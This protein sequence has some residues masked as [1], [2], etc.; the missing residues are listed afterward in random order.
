MALLLGCPFQ[1]G[2]LHAAHQEQGAPAAKQP[3]APQQ[4][5]GQQGLQGARQGESLL[6]AALA[7]SRWDW[8]SMC[9]GSR[10]C[11][12][13]KLPV[14][15]G[16]SEANRA[17]WSLGLT[18]AALLARG[19]VSIVRLTFPRPTA[20]GQHARSLSWRRAAVPCC[21]AFTPT[22]L[23]TCCHL[24]TGAE[25]GGPAGSPAG[26]VDRAHCHAAARS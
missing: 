3:A 8:C 6:A 5:G 17:V 15:G 19:S 24:H 25:G 16:E 18:G 11:R 4:P 21:P 26:G 13:I 7:M 1:G 12:S 2:L 23:P 10:R 9:G 20:A 22:Y 14:A